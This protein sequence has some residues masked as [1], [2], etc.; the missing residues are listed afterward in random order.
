MERRV[1]V[2][3][4]GCQAENKQL[5]KNSYRSDGG[6]M[7]AE[8]IQSMVSESTLE[9]ESTDLN[10]WQRY[11]AGL[12]SISVV[13]SFVRSFREVSFSSS[14]LSTKTRISRSEERKHKG[15][16]TAS[17]RRPLSQRQSFDGRCSRCCCCKK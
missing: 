11:I 10:A 12:D 16:V 5:A 14:L 13:R 3:T 8:T 9:D 15:T 7:V 4:Q 1:Y 2:T 17:G 6:L